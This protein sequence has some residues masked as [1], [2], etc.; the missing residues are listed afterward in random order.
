LPYR[1]VLQELVE[2][3]DAIGAEVAVGEAVLVA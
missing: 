2:S 3:F 1:V